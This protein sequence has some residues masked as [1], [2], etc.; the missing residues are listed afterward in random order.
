VSQF[1]DSLEQE[2]TEAAERLQRGPVW[3]H[4]LLAPARRAAQP[5]AA[6]A[7]VLAALAIAW[8]LIEPFLHEREQHPPS[9]RPSD[10]L[11]SYDGPAEATL[12]ITR[13]GYTLES[14]KVRIWGSV[15]VRERQIIFSPSEFNSVNRDQP[16]SYTIGSLPGG[17][18][19]QR[20][21]ARA[22]GLYA[23]SLQNGDLRLQVE[24]DRCQPRAAALTAGIW[25]RR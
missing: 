24:R 18:S 23:W 2:L 20:T 11:A 17:V 3:R 21:C 25:H 12:Q 14:T 8:A 5:L 22:V 6:A 1:I 13:T 16:P 10:V 7:A 4:R 19:Q 15:D 9:G